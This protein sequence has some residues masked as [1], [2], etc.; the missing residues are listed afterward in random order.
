MSDF[1]AALAVVA[2]VSLPTYLATMAPIAHPLRGT[3]RPVASGPETG[4]PNGCGKPAG[5][6]GPCDEGA[7]R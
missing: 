5:H 6:D 1:F 2:A 7:E 4:C 3:A